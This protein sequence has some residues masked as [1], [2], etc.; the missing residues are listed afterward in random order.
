[1]LACSVLVLHGSTLDQAIAQ[2][3]RARGVPVPDT[4]AQAAFIRYLIGAGDCAPESL[5]RET[6]E[7]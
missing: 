1:M 3:R 6:T 7:C 2:V 5:S 4:D